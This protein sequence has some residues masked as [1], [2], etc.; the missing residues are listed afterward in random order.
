MPT[1]TIKTPEDAKMFNAW[2]SNMPMPYT[3]TVVKG[4]KR[5]TAQNRLQRAWC[6]EVS[7]HF[8]DRT[9]EEVRGYCK[10]YFGVPILLGEDEEFAA[11]YEATVKPLPYEAKLAIMQEPLDLPVTRRMTVKQKVA[12]LDAIHQHFTAQGVQLTNPEAYA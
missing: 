8:G 6:N 3:A 10:A 4:V 12:Y 1:R 2:L 11:S 7:E 9:P 5:S